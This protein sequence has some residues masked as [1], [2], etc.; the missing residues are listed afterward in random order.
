M[1]VS[2]LLLRA[3]SLFIGVSSIYSFLLDMEEYHPSWHVSIGQNSYGDSTGDLA[4]QRLSYYCASMYH[5]LSI[6]AGPTLSLKICWPGWNGTDTGFDV[7]VRKNLL[8]LAVWQYQ[9]ID[10]ST[11]IPYCHCGTRAQL[12]QC[13]KQLHCLRGLQLIQ[14]PA[15][16]VCPRKLSLI[17]H[18]LI[19]FLRFANT[20]PERT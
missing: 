11:C 16:G 6:L 2:A 9:I 14:L 10:Y 12:C 13:W 4:Q 19:S 7:C 20:T 17:Q 1:P 3:M 5:G 18:L 8:N 15:N